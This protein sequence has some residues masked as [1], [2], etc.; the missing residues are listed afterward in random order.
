MGR[1]GDQHSTV[2]LIRTGLR[3][4]ATVACPV[5]SKSQISLYMK[6]STGTKDRL[7]TP[8]HSG[9]PCSACTQ[10]FLKTDMWSQTTVAC[11]VTNST[12]DRYVVGN[13]SGMSSYSPSRRQTCGCKPQWPVLWRNP[14]KTDIESRTPVA[15]P[16]TVN[17]EDRHV[18]A[19]HSGLSCYKLHWRQTWS[20]KPQWPVL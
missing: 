11:P 5:T 2:H 17:P 19:N 3:H 8:H 9:L 16:V 18:V 12:E 1:R 20:Q 15:C 10:S 6:T 13:H 4:P 7:E 14:L